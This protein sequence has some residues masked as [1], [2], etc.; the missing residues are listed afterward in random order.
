MI[1][2]KIATFAPHESD[3]QPIHSFREL[4][5]AQPLR[6]HLREAEVG[7]HGTSRTEP[8]THPHPPAVG[9]GLCTVL[10]VVWS[11]VS[12]AAGAVPFQNGRGLLQHQLRARGVCPRARQKLLAPPPFDGMDTLLAAALNYSFHPP[13]ARNQEKYV[14]NQKK[15]FY[16]FVY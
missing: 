12:G 11:G 5:R 10:S 9:D 14:E 1:W 15:S 7:T 6:H 2:K 13:L 3:L 8:R 16:L 4:P